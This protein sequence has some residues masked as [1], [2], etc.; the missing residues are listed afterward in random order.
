MTLTMTK[1]EPVLLVKVVEAVTGLTLDTLEDFLSKPSVQDMLE[2]MS[3]HL[4]K[5]VSG[6]ETA[7]LDVVIS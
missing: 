1:S 2:G 4:T 3:F 5:K 6:G 7:V